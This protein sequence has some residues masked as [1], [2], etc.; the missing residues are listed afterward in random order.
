MKKNP[1]I[2]PKNFKKIRFSFLKKTHLGV[3]VTAQMTR[4]TLGLPQTVDTNVLVT[5][6]L[7]VEGK[8]ITLSYTLSMAQGGNSKKHIFLQR[9]AAK[10]Y[11]LLCQ[12]ED[13]KGRLLV[14]LELLALVWFIF[15]KDQ[16]L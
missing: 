15:D 5:Q 8:R 16:G 6:Q 11:N 12:T 7:S 10:H 1:E 14:C 2:W 13:P 9:C 4:V 3:S